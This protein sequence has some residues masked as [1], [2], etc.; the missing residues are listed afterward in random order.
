[1]IPDTL[2]VYAHLSGP[3]R[4]APIDLWY[5]GVIDD[6]TFSRL[7]GSDPVRSN[8]LFFNTGRS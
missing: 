8:M 1:M 7:V 3:H 5:M 4:W 2:A 6:L